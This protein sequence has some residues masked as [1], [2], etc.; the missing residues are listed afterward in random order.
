[1]SAQ[2]K[3]KYDVPEDEYETFLAVLHS[4]IFGKVPRASS[5]LER[6]REQGPILVDLDLRY[7]TGGPLIR[8]FTTTHIRQ[9]NHRLPIERKAEA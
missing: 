8:R 2:D 5:L 1:M 3:G 6:H 9:F 4:H 7:Q